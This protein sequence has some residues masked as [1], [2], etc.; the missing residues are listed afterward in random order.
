MDWFGYY[1]NEIKQGGDGKVEEVAPGQVLVTMYILDSPLFKPSIGMTKDEFLD[2]CHEFY[3]DS[4]FD[5]N[6]FKQR[7]VSEFARGAFEYG[8]W[9]VRKPTEIPSFEEPEYNPDEPV[10][11]SEFGIEM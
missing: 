6:G 10:D 11:F 2:M 7:F 9:G 3:E 8:L 4:G 1:V 5:M